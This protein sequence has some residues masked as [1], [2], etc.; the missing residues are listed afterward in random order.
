MI[1]KLLPLTAVLLLP[2]SLSAAAP[3]AAP[4]FGE[5]VEVNVVNVDVFVTDKSGNRVTGLRKGDFEVLEDGKAVAASNFVEIT[6]A[7]KPAAQEPSPAAPAAP[8]APGAPGAPAPAAA[9]PAAPDPQRQLSLVVFVD[10]LHIRPQNRTRVVEQIRKFL[11]Q[12]VRPD[13]RVMIV[14]YDNN[15]HIR[16]SFTGNPAEVDAALREIETLPTYGQQEDALRRTTYQS[17]V[18]LNGMV[19]CSKD[20]IRPVEAY[21]DQMRGEAVRTIAALTVVI[22]SLSGVPGHRALLFVSDGI[23]VNPG[24]ELYQAASEL[25]DGSNNGTRISAGVGITDGELHPLSERIS[26]TGVEAARWDPRTAALDARK[27][28]LVDRFQKLAAHASSNRVTF[29]TLQASGLE[30]L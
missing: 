21:A 13:D 9:P 23:S 17:V 22:N 19:R 26:E 27:Y 7:G 2:A 12:S 15:L 20:M 4:S 8:P 6:P 3:P 10:N 30:T 24:E 28:S 14:S 5:T 18:D 1:K 25:C 11:A 16:R 29:Y